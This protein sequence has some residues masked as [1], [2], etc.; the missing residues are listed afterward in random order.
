MI[1]KS[2]TRIGGYKAFYSCN[3]LT[4]VVIPEGV[5]EIGGSA[6]GSCINLK[7]VVIPQGVKLVGS[8][9]FEGCTSLSSVVFPEQLNLIRNNAFSNCSSLT[10]LVIPEGVKEVGESAFSGCNNLASV[11]FSE[12]MERIGLKTFQGCSLSEIDLPMS[13]NLIGKDAFKLTRVKEIN[14]VYRH[15][16]SLGN[17]HPGFSRLI[18]NLLDD[19]RNRITKLLSPYAETEEGYDEFFGKLL[20]GKIDHLSEYDELFSA[21]R[22]T[23]E[24]KGEIALL[25]LAN[26]YELDEKHR[27]V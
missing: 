5:T 2:I 10:S 25:R 3:S 19:N 21:S 23:A 12:G 9:A 8:Q 26:P 27:E 4:S 17:G 15:R 11:T 16:A 22:G 18:I 14:I 1:P 24:Q 6:F 13:L 7:S 20:L